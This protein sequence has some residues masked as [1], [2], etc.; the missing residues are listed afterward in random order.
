MPSLRFCWPQFMERFLF[1]QMLALDFFL[2][3]TSSFVLLFS[4]HFSHFCLYFNIVEGFFCLFVYLYRVI[5]WDFSSDNHKVNITNV[6]TNCKT[7]Q[8]NQTITYCKQK[9]EYFY[10]LFPFFFSELSLLLC[11]VFV[12][13]LF[14]CSFLISLMMK[15]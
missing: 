12:F 9:Q 13:I 3:H 10:V 4:F 7:R 6:S 8:K 2:S 1:L 5:F 11:F 15:S 14:F